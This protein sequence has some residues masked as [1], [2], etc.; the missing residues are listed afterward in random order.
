MHERTSV[1]EVLNY[2]EYLNWPTKIGIIFVS[3]F[4][5]IQVIGEVLELKGKVVPEIIKI[6]K[7]FI[8]KKNEK[9]EM[10]QT[11]KEVKQLL[12]DVDA[13]YSSD[14]IAKRDSWIKWVNDRAI[15][16]DNSICE[17][18]EIS[19]NLTNVTDAL[20]SCTKMTEE[21]FIQSSRD[22]IID[23]AVKASSRDSVVS[24]EEFNRIFKVHD[25]YEK[26]LEEHEMTNGEI[27]I[28]YRII[29]E[30]YEQRMKNRTFIED[31]RGY[32]V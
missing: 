19:K 7:Y 11:L 28:A 16:Y 31:T 5:V 27:D 4:L 24:R 23:F 20:K 18:G 1:C 6:R 15:V 14:N 29:Q 12:G 25:R 26:F 9:K 22:R 10:M 32:D 2:I 30:S 8:R 21:M 13:H 3:I 17:I